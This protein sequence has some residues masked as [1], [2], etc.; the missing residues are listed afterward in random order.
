MR[1]WCKYLCVGICCLILQA[2]GAPQLT[3]KSTLGEVEYL[4]RYE[5]TDNGGHRMGWPGSGF[6]LRF[7]GTKLVVT[8]TD[9][10]GGIMDAVI[11][12]THS[13]LI[14]REGTHDYPLLAFDS[15]SLFEVSLT[16]RT[17][18][19][20]TGLF[21]IND[22]RVEGEILERDVPKHKILF[23][24]DSITAG[25]GLRGNTKDCKYTPS[26]NAPRKAYAWLASQAL[27]AEPQL[28][29]ISG[30]GVIQNHES[31][32]APVMPAQIDYALPDDESSWSHKDFAADVVVVTLGTNDWS[33]RNPG[34]N[35]FNAAYLALLKD[36]RAR[37]P[38][39]HIVTANGPLLGGAQGA[40]IRGGIDYAINEMSGTNI[41]SLD[42]SLSETQLKWGCDSHPGRDSMVKMANDLS[43]HIKAQMG[44]RAKTI[45][46]PNDLRINPPQEMKQDGKK[47][48]VQR[49]K[50]IAAY[51]PLDD[52]VLFLGDSI[53]EAGDWVKLFPNI[54]SANQ[55]ISWDTVAGVGSRLPQIILNSPDKIFIKIGTND[56]G[57]DHDPVDMAAE[58]ED[59]IKVLKFAR[60]DT[61]IYLQ[62]VLPREL[63]N[64]AKV[65]AI[66]AEYEKVAA[67]MNIPFI[68]LTGAFRAQ[69]GAM[70]EDLSD[71]EL[72]LNAKGYDVWRNAIRR[73]VLED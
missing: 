52:G 48:Y 1:S 13:A 70:R 50:E 23:I 43:A 60:P 20:D 57:Y 41:S 46:M 69:N 24:G 45:P 65:A 16:R 68:D 5:L 36:I 15:P 31:N 18:V 32:P 37:F 10:G 39:A 35:E 54:T 4:G 2:C 73:Y 28:I 22:I 58:L 44:W 67:D 25:Y 7:R 42:F 64:K 21:E 40:A 3:G 17:E 71:D 59:V 49:V 55:G 72:H 26:S 19:F 51:P 12:G 27:D 11:N 66:N 9:D 8:L 14:L 34:Q 30:R 62:S 6:A 53:T 47:H 63:S 56:I 38:K 33:T 61:K 29:A